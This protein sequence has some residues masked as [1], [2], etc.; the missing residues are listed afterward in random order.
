MDGLIPMWEMLLHIRSLSLILEA[1][2]CLWLVDYHCPASLAATPGRHT[3]IS[4]FTI[5]SQPPTG[6][7]LHN[8]LGLCGLGGAMDDTQVSSSL[9]RSLESWFDGNTGTES[10]HRDI[11]L[12]K[13]TNI[14]N[15]RYCIHWEKRGYSDVM[16]APVTYRSVTSIT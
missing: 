5:W 12:A 10:N 16:E 13:C 11:I 9:S 4:H 6:W 3:A 14:I 1:S 8:D 7:A 15:P 2:C